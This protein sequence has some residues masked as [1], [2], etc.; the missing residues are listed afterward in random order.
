MMGE[1][2]ENIAMGRA[3]R[4]NLQ[5]ALKFEDFIDGLL[6]A[7]AIIDEA[8]MVV[9]ASPPA[10]DIMDLPK[11]N[12]IGRPVTGAFRQCFDRAR[13]KSPGGAYVNFEKY[14]GGKWYS[15]Q[16]Y[17]LSRY[18]SAA[19]TA[20]TLISMTDISD[21]KKREFELLESIAGLE[22]ATRI[23]RMGTFRIDNIAN[24]VVWSPHTYT[25]HGVTPDRFKPTTTNYQQLVVPE[26]RQRSDGAG[27]RAALAWRVR[28]SHRQARR[29]DPLGLCR[30]AAAVRHRRRTA[31]DFRHR[32]GHHRGQE[33]RTGIAATA[34]AQRHTL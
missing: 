5:L 4:P 23:A 11:A 22:E 27:G 18:Q 3:S 7:I 6:S 24:T 25:L 34:A 26:D 14:F 32:P 30:P 2:L 1:G 33:S 21:R 12:A 17:A 9:M 29:R 19:A 15:V 16:S 13:E 8:G 28:I 10:F 31:R 20:L